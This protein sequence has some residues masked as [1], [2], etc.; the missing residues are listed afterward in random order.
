MGIAKQVVYNSG[1]KKKVECSRK[2][3]GG[4]G[5]RDTRYLGFLPVVAI[6]E[7]EIDISISPTRLKT[8]ALKPPTA[9]GRR[10]SAAFATFDE[11]FL[12]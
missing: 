2:D 11:Y 6:C 3:R 9:Q 4:A 10:P 8:I 7:F 5:S 1:K 12:H